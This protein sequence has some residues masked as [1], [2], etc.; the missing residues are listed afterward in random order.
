MTI[1]SVIWKIHW[2][3]RKESISLPVGGAQ[4]EIGGQLDI[5]YK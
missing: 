2:I 4:P 3:I 5:A 1:L